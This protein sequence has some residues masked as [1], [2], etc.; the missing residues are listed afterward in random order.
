LFLAREFDV[1]V[2]GGGVIG[3]AAA[4]EI[5]RRGG[6]HLSVGLVEKESSLAVHAS[7]RNSGVLHS[8]FNLK[9]GS[10]KARL[11]V[12]GN[13]LSR[14]FCSARKVP[15]QT[16]GTVVVG[17]GAQD[18]AALEELKRRGDANGVPDLRLVDAEGLKRLEPHA[19]GDMALHSPTGAIV[20]A[21]GFV[22]SL[23]EEARSSGVKFLTGARVVAV[24][25]RGAK[26]SV[27]TT[28]GRLS[29]RFLV[30]CAGASSDVIARTLGLGRN[31]AIVPF[32]GRYFRLKPERSHLVRSMIYPVPD[33]D[34]PF[35]GVHF[36]RR[37]NGE[38]IVGPDAT[39]ALGREGYDLAHSR[40]WELLATLWFPGAPRGLARPGFAKMLAESSL[41]SASRSGFC[42][43]A[44]KLVPELAPSDLIPDTCG[45]RAQLLDSRGML[46][47]DFVLESGE[48]SLHVLNPVSPGMTCS[49]PMAKLIADESSRMGYL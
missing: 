7:G 35:L 31:Y 33:L 38:T 32:G 3:V 42:R 17:K 30:N 16:T 2:I 20:D 28:K 44:R 34:Y 25:E 37:V 43:L 39:L 9:P 6:A 4:R 23:A 47:D 18:R 19:R 36:T 45:I 1:L 11:C 21:R 13:R 27:M 41:V 48:R 26:V 15:M 29:A 12:E 46:V 40:P 5:A 24:S 8:G 22:E 10:L 49:L 14:E